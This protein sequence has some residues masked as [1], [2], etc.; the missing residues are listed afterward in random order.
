MWRSP[1]LV[2]SMLAS[3]CT[4]SNEKIAFVWPVHA[5]VGISMLISPA[6]FRGLE[7]SGN[8]QLYIYIYVSTYCT[9]GTMIVGMVINIVSFVLD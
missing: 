5:L 6:A 8:Q 4:C 1:L 9:V 3:T 2:Y 7:Q